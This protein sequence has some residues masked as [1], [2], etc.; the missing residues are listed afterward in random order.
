MLLTIL[1]LTD[2]ATVA[3]IGLGLGFHAAKPSARSFFRVRLSTQ[4]MRE[5]SG[6][7]EVLRTTGNPQTSR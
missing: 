3:L 6:H 4:T 7:H 1:V 5:W 2:V